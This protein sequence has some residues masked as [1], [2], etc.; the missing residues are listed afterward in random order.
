M[1][2]GDIALRKLVSELG[3]SKDV[4]FEDLVSKSRLKDLYRHADIFCLPSLAEPFGKAVIE[5]MACGKQVIVTDTKGPSEIVSNMREGVIVPRANYKK[6]AEAITVLFDQDLRN[7][8]GK[9]ARK[10]AEEY[11]WRRIAE[12]LYRIYRSCLEGV[13]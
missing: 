2:D 12:K 1:E 6:L 11:S 10:R 9:L 3:L 4:L 5:A 7:F 8:M 13:Q